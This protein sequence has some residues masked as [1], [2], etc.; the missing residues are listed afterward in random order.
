MDISYIVRVYRNNNSTILGVVENTESHTRKKFS[1]AEELWEL[2]TT[3]SKP[4]KI[5]SSLKLI[6]S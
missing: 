3:N 4:R 2:I 6:V 1:C 5:D